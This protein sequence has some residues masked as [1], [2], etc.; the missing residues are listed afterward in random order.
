MDRHE[1]VQRRLE[2]AQQS[3]ADLEQ[4]IDATANQI[5]AARLFRDVQ[6]QLKLPA[7][8]D[9]ERTLQLLRGYV[10]ARNHTRRLIES[11]TV[12][13]TQ[14]DQPPLSE[15]IDRWETELVSLIQSP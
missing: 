3:L 1:I 9:P 12:L 13:E 7:D 14:L 5:L 8:D 6:A 11:L 10:A 2:V 15:Q 4:I